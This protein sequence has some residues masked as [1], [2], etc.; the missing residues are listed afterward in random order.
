[1]GERSR[2]DRWDTAGVEAVYDRRCVTESNITDHINIRNAFY[3]TPAQTPR[4]ARIT[5]ELP[6]NNC[7]NSYLQLLR[8]VLFPD[9]RASCLEGCHDLEA[10]P[11]P[12]RARGPASYPPPLDTNNVSGRNQVLVM[13]LGGGK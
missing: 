12:E 6:V 1:M 3:N 2:N 13:V 8:D 4:P 9:K 10:A 7:P 11:E 5:F